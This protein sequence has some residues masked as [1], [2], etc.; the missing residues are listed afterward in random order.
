MKRAFPH[1]SFLFLSIVFSILTHCLVLGQFPRL[2]FKSFTEKD[3]LS[4]DY[5]R[6]IF[7]DRDGFMWFGTPDGIDK[8]DG[9]S[10]TNY[11]NLFKDSLI[12]TLKLS[13][14]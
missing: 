5:V 11:N 10:F 4:K 8:F 7:Q 6:T 3:G 9:K 12:K 1:K 14:V 2:N 13:S